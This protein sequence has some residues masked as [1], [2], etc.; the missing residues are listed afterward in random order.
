MTPDHSWATSRSS[1]IV[2]GT[3]CFLLSCLRTLSFVTP[4]SVLLEVSVWDL[5][6]Q[7]VTVDVASHWVVVFCRP[8]SL[9]GL[10]PM[11]LRLETDKVSLGCCSPWSIEL[12]SKASQLLVVTPVGPQRSRCDA[13]CTLRMKPQHLSINSGA[14]D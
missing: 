6:H 7:P 8:I 2:N 14:Y 13:V 12:S 4:S 3:T 1:S 11:F 10:A 9:K 5:S